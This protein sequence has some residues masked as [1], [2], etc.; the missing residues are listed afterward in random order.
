MICDLDV[1]EHN[2]YNLVC[3]SLLN[4]FGFSSDSECRVNTKK[5]FQVQ[6]EKGDRWQGADMAS[7]LQR[8]KLRH[9]VMFLFKHKCF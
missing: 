7:N 1:V 4:R 8:E 3:D 2:V 9:E 6:D 5:T